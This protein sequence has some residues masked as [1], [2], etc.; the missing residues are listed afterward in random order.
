MSVDRLFLDSQNPR[1]PED[2]YGKDEEGLLRIL[3]NQ[4]YI[5]ELAESMSRNGYFDEEPLV[6]VPIGTPD[7]LQNYDSE[8]ESERRAI[9]TI[10]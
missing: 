7:D 10:Y 2:A 9:R 4:F 6:A 5:D 1:L 8:T 3:Y